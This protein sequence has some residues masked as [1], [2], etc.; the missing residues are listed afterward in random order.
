[1]WKV[2]VLCWTVN[3]IFINMLIISS[4]AWKLWGLIH[5]ITNNFSSLDSYKILYV[6]LIGSKFEYS[7]VAWNNLTLADSNKLQNTQKKFLSLC[8]SWFDQFD[9]FHNYDLILQYLK[10]RTFYFRWQHPD[11]LF[12]FNVL[13]E[14]KLS[15]W[16]DY[17]WSSCTH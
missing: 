10:C 12:L 6:A 17:C 15:L 2:S 4:E 8:Y 14:N 9:F 5:F 3:Y 16:Y 1:V 11:G 13:W 7:S